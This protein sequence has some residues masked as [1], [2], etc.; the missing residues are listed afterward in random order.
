M[1]E[2]I[3]LSLALHVITFHAYSLV[4]NLLVTRV[5]VAIFVYGYVGSAR[6]I[7]AG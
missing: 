4:V 2:N 3:R 5:E 7:V 6:P 1:L